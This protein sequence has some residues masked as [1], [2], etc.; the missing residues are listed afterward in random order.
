MR[1]KAFPAFFL[2][3]LLMIA[4][5]TPN[6][7]EWKGTI[8]E[9]D[10]VL[11][12]KNPKEPMY[13]EGVFQLEDELSIGE[14]SGSNEYIFSEI[15]DITV[16]DKGR[17]Y[18]LDPSEAH[19]KVFDKDGKYLRTIG[20]EGQG[21][22]EIGAPRSVFI[23]CHKE[24]MVPD[25][26]NRRLT[27]FSLEG[28][29][30][31][32]ISTAKTSLRSTRVD[33]E[34]NIVGVVLIEEESWRHELNKFDSDMKYIF[35]FTS[36]PAP[37]PTRFNTFMPRLRWTLTNNDQVVCG[38][39][40]KYEISFFNMKGEAIRKII[41]DYEPVEINK[42]EIERLKKISNTINVIKLKYKSAYQELTVDDKG[43][44]FV[45]TWERVNDKDG[46]YYDIFDSEGKY[47]AKIH[48]MTTPQII[49]KNKLYTIEEDEDSY[50]YVK[51]YKV[52]WNY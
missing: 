35:S 39:P 49:K 42:V 30:I 7:T 33:S 11:I 14:E 27:F 23:T 18:A 31:R 4:C 8:E 10:G 16:D 36:V 50:Q 2:L 46:F 32:N 19:I 15:S 51:R 12:V 3:S 34:G 22:G 25:M 13:E 37:S 41:K 52:T 40:Q 1:A 47:I 6:D 9:E 29:F 24:I 28:E 21:P 45:M 38:Y 26:I 20:R 43:N 48:L 17:I 5:C 44:I